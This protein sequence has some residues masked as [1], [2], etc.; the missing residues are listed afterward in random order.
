[1]SD[2]AAT[3]KPT[4]AFFFSPTS[5]PSRR[6]EAYLAQ[7]LQRR[8][9]HATF[10]LR[11]VNIDENHELAKRFE[12]TTV[13][14]LVVVEN[15]RVRGR[16]EGRFGGPDIDLLLEPWLSAGSGAGLPRLEL[17]ENCPA[18]IS[19]AA[20]VAQLERWRAAAA[21]ESLDLTEWLRSVAD[22]AS[23]PADSTLQAG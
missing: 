17:V 16:L 18:S 22:E 15:R 23:R 5:G 2:S 6:V 3:G 7:V 8:R 4:L 11:R 10:A 21:A 12:V 19:L 9:N 14:T 1:M 13:P 20:D